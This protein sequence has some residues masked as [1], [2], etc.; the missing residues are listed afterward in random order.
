MMI[1]EMP[2]GKSF[3]DLV[4]LPLPKVDKP[5]L[6][7]ELKNNKAVGTAI[8]QIKQKNYPDAIKEYAGN[9]ILVG[10][11]YNEDKKHECLIEKI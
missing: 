11:T 9:V 4:F 5:A 2:A 8:D 7:I 6:V 10:I 1:R 3:A